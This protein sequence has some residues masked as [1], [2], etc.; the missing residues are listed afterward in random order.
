MLLADF[1]F[2]VVNPIFAKPN[3]ITTDTM[4]KKLI[5]N[6][7]MGKELSCSEHTKKVSP[8]YLAW[9]KCTQ[10]DYVMFCLMQYKTA[11]LCVEAKINGYLFIWF[12]LDFSCFLDK[13]RPMKRKVRVFNY[14]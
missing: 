13:K 10:T 4:L 6:K 5:H 8:V 14:V 9:L 3:S 12:V 7:F 2:G 11:K 1:S